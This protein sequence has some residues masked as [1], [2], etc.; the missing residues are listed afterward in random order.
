MI[1][2]RHRPAPAQGMS[3]VEVLIAAAIMAIIA[4]GLLPLFARSV[5]QNREGANYTEATNVARSTLEGYIA[6]DFNAPALT[7]VGSATQLQ[8]VQ[9]YDIGL[10]RWVAVGTPPSDATKPHRYERTVI[11]EQFGSGDLLDDGDLDT[12]L[13]GSD[14]DSLVQ[15]KRIRVIV[16]P[17]W[18]NNSILGRPSPVSLETLKT[19]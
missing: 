1:D 2:T 11:V 15:L 17:L 6:L 13:K 7:L 3:L 18:K 5:R 16:R 19:V 12:P 4:L 14:P 9:V 10:Q 8:T